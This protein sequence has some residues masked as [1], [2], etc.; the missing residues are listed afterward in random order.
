MVVAR[1]APRQHALADRSLKRLQRPAC[2]RQPVIMTSSNRSARCMEAILNRSAWIRR[3]A[4]ALVAHVA[5]S[6]DVVLDQWQHAL[7][8]AE[9]CSPTTDRLIERVAAE[10]ELAAALLEVPELS[11]SVLLWRYYATMTNAEIAR[12]CGIPLASVVMRGRIGLDALRAKLDARFNGD[13]R[14]WAVALVGSA[15]RLRTSEP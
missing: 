7:R 8:L 12:T 3:L 14:R 5:I 13:S 6:D 11:R 1:V 4:H 2:R 10:L 15:I 9:A